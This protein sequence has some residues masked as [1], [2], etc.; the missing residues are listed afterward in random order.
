M[1]NNFS[2]KVEIFY[3]FRFRSG[4]KGRRESCEIAT[5]NRASLQF[6]EK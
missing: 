4:G 2:E 5:K 3:I 6:A 1:M